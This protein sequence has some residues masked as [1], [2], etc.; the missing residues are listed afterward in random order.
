MR[1]FANITTVLA[2]LSVMVMGVVYFRGEREKKTLSREKSPNLAENEHT[3]PVETTYER[4]LAAANTA[5]FS[6]AMVASIMEQWKPGE[7]TEEQIKP[8]HDAM[9]DLEDT[10]KIAR[11]LSGEV[12]M[13]T[14]QQVL[15]NYSKQDG[16]SEPVDHPE[17]ATHYGQEGIA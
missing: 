3:P 2:F 10:S 8:I 16:L 1:L 17:D 11:V 9:L 6:A 12:Y 7:V 4:L 14:E 15:E 5:T 13:A